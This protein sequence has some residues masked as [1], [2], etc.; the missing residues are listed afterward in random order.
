MTSSLS[1]FIAEK[2]EKLTRD[3]DVSREESLQ[4]IRKTTADQIDVTKHETNILFK[5]I[6]TKNISLKKLKCFDTDYSEVDYQKKIDSFVDFKMKCPTDQM[7]ELTRT[8]D[9]Y[10]DWLAEVK[11]R[12]EEELKKQERCLNRLTGT[13]SSWSVSGPP[14]LD[15]YSFR[16]NKDIWVTGLGCGS[17]NST[18]N[19]ATIQDIE[20]RL[21]KSTRGDVL[22]RHPE[23]VTTTYDGT[24]EKKFQK[25]LF[26]EPVKITKN[27]DYCIRVCYS[28]GGSIWS[29]NGTQKTQQDGVTFTFSSATFTGGDNDNGSSASSGPCRDIYFALAEVTL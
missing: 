3:V 10:Q 28:S 20:I 27:T 9:E 21:S 26:T 19:T 4:F 11:R 18:G 23:T 25:V 6:K 16:T 8:P 17:G 1:T 29:G 5:N 15:A 14:T 7:F 22:Y 2:M 24:E 12:K 13:G